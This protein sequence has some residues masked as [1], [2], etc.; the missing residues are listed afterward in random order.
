[1]GAY[2]YTVTGVRPSTGSGADRGLRTD[3]ITQLLWPNPISATSLSQYLQEKKDWVVYNQAGKMVDKNSLYQAGIYLV[4]D[5]V[6]GP[7]Q[8]IIVLP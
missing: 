5:K 1:M 7:A 8:K 4:Q 2:E 3:P 6:N